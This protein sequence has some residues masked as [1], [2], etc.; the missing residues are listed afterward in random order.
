MKMKKIYTN[1]LISLLAVFTI[2]NN[3]LIAKEIDESA[4]IVHVANFQYTPNTSQVVSRT[5][6]D[7]LIHGYDGWGSYFSMSPGDMMITVY[8]AETDGN[9]KAVNIPVAHWGSSSDDLTISIHKT[10]YPFNTNGDEYD[11][12]SVNGAGWLGGYDEDNNGILE[13]TGSNWIDGDGYYGNCNNTDM[14]DNNQDPLGTFSASS[15]PTGTPLKGLLW[16]DG[17]TAATLNPADHPDLNNGGGD[18]WI[19]LSDYGTEPT[20]AQGDYICVAVHYTGSG[21]DGS[22]PNVGFMHKQYDNRP[23]MSLKFYGIECGGTSGENGWHIR[24]VVF[25]FQLQ[26]E[27]TSDR[28]PHF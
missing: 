15:G 10:S 12:Y 16:P 26:V 7:T 23:W 19:Q 11:Q 6:M 13:L 9:L 20:V 18:N 3:D 27:Y 4:E 21:G 17:S 25:N 5:L 8:R 2:V 14:I 22:D 24:G 28:G 1:S